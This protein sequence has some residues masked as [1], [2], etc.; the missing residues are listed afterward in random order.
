[1][2]TLKEAKDYVNNNKIDG[3]RCPCCEQFAKVYFRQIHSTMARQLILLWQFNRK[4][5][6]KFIHFSMIR[7]GSGISDFSKLKYWL[8]VEQMPHDYDN[9]VSNASGYWR[10][11]QA[12]VDFINGILSVRKKVMIYNDDV[13]GFVGSKV[14]I[15]DCLG[16]KFNYGELMAEPLYE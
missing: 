12:G 7:I 15:H 9:T 3:V 11:T 8:L 1:M 16:K 4:E 14:D 5:R 10:I 6:K 13:L 2:Y